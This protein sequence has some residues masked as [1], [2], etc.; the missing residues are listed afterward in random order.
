MNR[1]C[2]RESVSAPNR[3]GVGP[4]VIV[5]SEI[6]GITPQM[7]A[8]AQRVV[9]AGHTVFMPLLFGEPMRPPE[10]GYALRVL[11]GQ[12]TRDALERTLAFLKEQLSQVQ[13]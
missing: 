8:F 5:M 2:R 11:A 1:A 13:A 6:P 3:A 10:R 4:A 9:E 7:A 12:P